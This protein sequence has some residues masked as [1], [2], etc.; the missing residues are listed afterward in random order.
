MWHRWTSLEA[1]EAWHQAA[2]SHLGLPRPGKGA[3]SRRE[4][5]SA[6]WTTAY[7]EPIVL[8]ED[9]VRA[10]V[11]PLVAKEL[12]V[13]LGESCDPPPPPSEEAPRIKAG[14]KD[15]PIWYVDEVVKTQVESKE[16]R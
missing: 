12:P 8:A 14:T 5:P 3:A 13:G 16:A 1:Y 4:R 10:I 7:T 6:Q 2:M 15:Q 9:D 11:E